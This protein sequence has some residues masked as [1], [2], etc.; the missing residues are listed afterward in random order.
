MP[1]QARI[2][3]VIRD[4]SGVIMSATLISILGKSSILAIEALAILQGLK[5]CLSKGMKS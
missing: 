1:L 4:D 2:G 5:F 3:F